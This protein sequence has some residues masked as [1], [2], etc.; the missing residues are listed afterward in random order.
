M[1][2]IEDLLA[3]AAD[4]TGQPLRYTV[5]DIVVRGRRSARNRRVA[6][7]AT[8][9]L[10][11]AAVLVGAAVWS[12]S[13]PDSAAPVGSDQST[14]PSPT[15]DAST[16]PSTTPG[17][18]AVLSD[19]KPVITLTKDPLTGKKIAPPTPVSKLTD[20]QV[21]QRCRGWEKEIETNPT[22]GTPGEHVGGPISAAWTVALKTGTGDALTAAILSPDKKYVVTCHMTKPSF[23]AGGESDYGR[24]EVGADGKFADGQDWGQL[25]PGVTQVVVDLPKQGPT[26]ALLAGGFYTWGVTGGNDDIKNVRIRGFDA[27]GKLVFDQ[28]RDIDAS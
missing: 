23:D 26:H 24:D 6:G 16:S 21:R 1:G 13:R 25:P 3:A 17:A 20:D 28:K 5:D 19:T 8:A 22:Y 15:P 2:K 4:D 10:T 27:K 7:I 18:G 12:G 11:T 14:S 9:T